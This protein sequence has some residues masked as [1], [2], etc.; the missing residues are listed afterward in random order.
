MENFHLVNSLRDLE[1]SHLVSNL[2]WGLWGNTEHPGWEKFHLE[3]NLGCGE[4]SHWVS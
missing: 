2:R 3:S 1:S 4:A